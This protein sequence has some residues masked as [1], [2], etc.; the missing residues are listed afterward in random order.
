MESR[1]FATLILKDH[2]SLICKIQPGKDATGQLSPRN[3][4]E[5]SPPCVAWGMGEGTN[6]TAWLLAS[7]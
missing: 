4:P 7:T 2:Y 6:L 5:T 1:E 3:H